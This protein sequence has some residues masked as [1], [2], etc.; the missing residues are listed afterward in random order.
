MAPSGVHWR[1][2]ISVANFFYRNH[3]AILNEIVLG[4]HSEQATTI[5][6]RF[7]SGQDNQYFMWNDASQDNARSLADKFLTRFLKL[8]ELD[9]GCDYPYAGWYLRLLWLAK[10]GWLPVVLSDYSDVSY[11]RVP[12]QD[13]RPKEWPRDNEETPTLPLPPSGEL[14]QDYKI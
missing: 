14:Q 9:K 2:T 10:A 5:V 1:C 11:D 6:A 8:A 12:L 3:G 7:T 4:D 13:V